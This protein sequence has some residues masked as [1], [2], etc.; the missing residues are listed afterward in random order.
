MITAILTPICTGVTVSLIVFFITRYYSVVQNKKAAEI[1][2]EER[3]RITEEKLTTAKIN[4]L[5]ELSKA[6]AQKSIVELGERYITQG[7]VTTSELTLIE[8]IYE[9]Y[10]KEPLDGNHLAHNIMQ[11]VRKLPLVEEK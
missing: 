3:T 5:A 8:T 10:H 7:C 11:V 2:R 4:A 1:E 6:M 9:P